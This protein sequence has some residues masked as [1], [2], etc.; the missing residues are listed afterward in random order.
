MTTFYL[1]RHGEPQWELC[2]EYGLIGHGRD[3]A[4]LN[5][6]GI[7]QA[8]DIS[9]DPRLKEGQIIIS[10]PYTR[11]LQTAA[12]ISKNTNIDIVVE[13][14]L[15]EWQPDL[16][17][18]YDSNKRMIEYRNDFEKHNGI[19]PKD[20]RVNWETKASLEKRVKGVL[21]KYLS[22]DKVIVVAHGMV[23]RTINKGEDLPHCGLMPLDIET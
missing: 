1:V 22:Y 8:H 23:F 16:T 11:A 18:R 7:K 12:I 20:R 17:F 10:S 6:K 21:N 2:D 5:Q 9:M 15:R 13:F 4:P 14:D 3:L 19:P